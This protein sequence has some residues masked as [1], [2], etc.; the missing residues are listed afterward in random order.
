M[1]CLVLSLEMTIG[2]MRISSTHYICFPF[3]ASSSFQDSSTSKQNRLMADISASETTSKAA[4][5]GKTHKDEARTW[6]RWAEYCNSI[7]L[8]R[9]K[10]LDDYKNISRSNSLELSPWLCA[11]DIFQDRIMTPWLKA[12]IRGDISYVAQTFQDN[13]RSNPTRDE[14]GELEQLLSCL[15]RSFKNGD[16]SPFQQKAL[17]ACAL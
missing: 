15:H 17:P 9:D 2:T 8:K 4:V 7:G 12:Q 5:T 1:M 13:G 14:D 6:R 11:K 16:P 3:S 10:F